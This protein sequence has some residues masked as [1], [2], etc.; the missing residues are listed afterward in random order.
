MPCVS[1]DLSHGEQRRIAILKDQ[2]SIAQM[3]AV[4]TRRITGLKTRRCWRGTRRTSSPPPGRRR[5]WW[6]RGSSPPAAR[7][8]RDRHQFGM[9]ALQ[10]NCIST[11]T[12]SRTLRTRSQIRPWRSTTCSEMTVRAQWTRIL[13][14]TAELSRCSAT[15]SRYDYFADGIDDA[16]AHIDNYGLAAVGATFD[17]KPVH[18]RRDASGRRSRRP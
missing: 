15:P 13:G 7:G 1:V 18:S 5:R 9:A 4:P 14:P 16:R 12:A 11:S 8:D 17:G 6:R 3:L 2:N 10:N